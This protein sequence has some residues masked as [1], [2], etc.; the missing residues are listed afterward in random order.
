MATP[1]MFIGD[2]AVPPGVA[3]APGTWRDLFTGPTVA[4]LEGGLVGPHE[5]P[6]SRHQLFNTTRVVDYLDALNVRAVT[7]ANNHITDVAPSPQTTIDLLA[8]R[9]IAACGAGACLEESTRPVTFDDGGRLRVFLAFGWEVIGCRAARAARPGVNPLRPQALLSAVERARAAHPDAT[10]T[11]L[12]HWNYEFELFPQPMH[13]QLAFAAVE[14][15]ADAVVGCHPH[16]VGGV[17]IH[18]GAPI[19]YSLGN[20]LLPH[21]VFFGGRLR[22]PPAADLQ[23]AF[24]WQPEDGNMVCHWFE[25]QRRDHSLV[26]LRSEHVADSQWIAERTPFAGMP[27]DEYTRWF[28]AHRRRRRGLPVYADYRNA[29]PNWCRDRYVG[30]RN[31]AIR[32]LMLFHLKAGPSMAPTR[33]ARGVQ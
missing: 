24:E 6:P 3:M 21:G 30:L 2:I 12:V 20:W 4:N 5:R 27:H 9:N 16:C 29:G 22:Y 18:R 23:L 25:Y 28:G 8:A 15:G 26:H 17:E 13:R 11:L 19:V 7:L 32:A 10:I 33:R 1:V 31:R 14:R